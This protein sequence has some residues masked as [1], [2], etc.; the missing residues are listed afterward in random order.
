M[1]VVPLGTGAYKRSVG[2]VPEVQCH[3]MYLEKDAS[4]ISPDGTL[5]IQRPGMITVASHSAGPIRDLTVN[6]ANG[7]I[8]TV[9]GTNF[10]KN[11][12]LVGDVGSSSFGQARIIVTALTVAIFTSDRLTLFDGTTL[13]DVPLPALTINLQVIPAVDIDQL[14]GYIIVLYEN[15][16]FYWLVPGDTTIDPLNF[17]TAESSNDRALAVRQVG[18]EFWIMGGRTAEPWQATGNFGSPFE[19]ATGR[20]VPHGC[21]ARD[22]VQRFDNTLVWVGDDCNVYRAGGVAEIIST[23]AIAERIR[24]RNFG[25]DPSAWTFTQDAHTFYVLRVAFE[26]TFL[27]DAATQEWCKWA[28]GDLEV[29][30]AW[31]GDTYAGRVYAGSAD[32]GKVW[33]ISPDYLTDDSVA[34]PRRVTGSVPVLGKPPLNS[35]ISVGVGASANTEVRIRWRDGQEDYPA[36]YYDVLEVRAPFDVCSMYRLGEPQQPYREVEI[37]FIGEEQVRIA[38]CLFNQAWQ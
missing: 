32:N 9:S 25:V 11:N 19:V 33:E 18:A 13:T 10:Y 8:Y 17:A 15:G 36:D 1:P 34:F 26:G 28:S 6:Q 27:Y 24:K 12:T 22:T 23:P 4:G 5:R 7:E 37:S 29:W 20:V 21:L 16:R 14:N 30:S 2:L 38:G 35:S 3:N 31:V